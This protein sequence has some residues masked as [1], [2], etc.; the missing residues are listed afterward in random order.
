MKFLTGDVELISV[1]IMKLFA[2]LRNKSVAFLN[3][4]SY[5][6]LLTFLLRLTFIFEHRHRKVKTM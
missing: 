2:S 3:A 5:V 6:T 1:L 4:E